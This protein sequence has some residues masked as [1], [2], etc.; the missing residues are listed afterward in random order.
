MLVLIIAYALMIS[1]LPT[2][3]PRTMLA[4]HF[5]HAVTWCMIHYVG[6]GLILQAQSKTKFLVRHFIKN[7]HYPQ[8]DGGG[9]A[10]VEA[11]NNWKVIYN[12]S[13]CMTYG[14]FPSLSHGSTQSCVPLVSCV[15]V[16]WK[17]YSLP[18]DWTVGNE[19]LR[20]TLGV[21]RHIA[22]SIERFLTN[23]LLASRWLARLGFHG[24]V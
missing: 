15:G 13:M 10:I 20:H 3:S 18:H 4:L 6:L 21:V 14:L 9:G 5:L 17:S 7:Y 22:P 2:L 1:F 8:N 12:L 11:F 16:V 23:N 19:L 24:V